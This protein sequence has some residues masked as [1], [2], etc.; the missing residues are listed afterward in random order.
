MK[1]CACI[2]VCKKAG[3]TGVHTCIH[4]HVHADSDL[5]YTNANGTVSSEVITG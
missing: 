5:N 1:V 4:L 3:I 2:H